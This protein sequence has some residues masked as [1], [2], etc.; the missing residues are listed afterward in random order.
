MREDFKIIAC[1]LLVAIFIA[2]GIPYGFLGWHII[3][4]ALTYHFF[5]AN[6]FHL[7][8]NCFCLWQLCRFGKVTYKSLAV[9]FVIATITPLLVHAPMVG[10]SNI[11]YALTG[12]AFYSFAR[13]NVI[14]LIA[15]TAAMIPFPQIAAVPHL[16]S[17][18]L[19][20][21]SIIIYTKF[22]LVRND[23]KTLI[24]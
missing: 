9:A 8:G 3:P 21:V 18:I 13:K 24:Y 22:N 14:I 17:L 5:H 10:F 15:A 6:I 1:G 4:R 2:I 20:M 16:V 12:L 11:L 7:I 23:I 19:G